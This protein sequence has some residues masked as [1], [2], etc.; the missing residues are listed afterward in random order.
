MILLRSSLFGPLQLRRCPDPA[1]SCTVRASAGVDGP[2]DLRFRCLA[3]HDAASAANWLAVAVTQ[4]DDMTVMRQ[5]VAE[6][7]RPV[8]WLSSAQVVEH[9]ARKIAQRD[10]CLLIP[11]RPAT[12]S[13]MSGRARVQRGAEVA[14]TPSML[15]SRAETD[16]R[17]PTFA[18]IAEITDDMDQAMQ[19]AVLEEAARDGVPFCE[20]CA[21]ARQARS[22]A[23]SSPA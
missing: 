16:E 11:D 20:V 3:I 1:S 12:G 8:A 23:A 22:S 10:L 2:D 6:E 14:A 9:V 21:K 13:S 5:V 19:A 15:R 4:S 17:L 18:A 7:G